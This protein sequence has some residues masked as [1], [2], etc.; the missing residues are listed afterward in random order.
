MKKESEVVP[1]STI[2]PETKDQT[3]S[4]RSSNSKT[5]SDSDV[6]MKLMSQ[7]EQGLIDEDEFR[8]KVALLMNRVNIVD[9]VKK[10][11]N[12]VSEKE[13]TNQ[14]IE[15]KILM[16]KGDMTVDELKSSF[17]ISSGINIRIY[18]GKRFADGVSALNSLG[19]KYSKPLKLK[20]NNMM[21]VGDFEKAFK[22]KIGLSIQIENRRG[23]LADNSLSLYQI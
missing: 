13:N 17:K 1:P 7:F 5:P 19:Y 8:K 15:P 23:K 11:K 14:K 4:I 10:A 21:M 22:E 6:L 12:I 18:D 3:S 2:H 9:T 16:I 20:L